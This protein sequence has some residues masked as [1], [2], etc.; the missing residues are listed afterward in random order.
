MKARV[1]D[2]G[3]RGVAV[4]FVARFGG[5]AALRVTWPRF[6][7][8]RTN[9]RRRGVEVAIPWKIYMV[10]V[11]LSRYTSVFYKKLSVA[12]DAREAPI[13]FIFFKSIYSCLLSYILSRSPFNVLCLNHREASVSSKILYIFKHKQRVVPSCSSRLVKSTLS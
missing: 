3:G 6:G 2:D 7:R 8:W 10:R 5:D 4:R 1:E 9:E 11:C 12:M 13:L